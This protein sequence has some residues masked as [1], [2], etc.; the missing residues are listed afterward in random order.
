M[1][2]LRERLQAHH[3]QRRPGWQLLSLLLRLREHAHPWDRSWASVQRTRFEIRRAAKRAAAAPLVFPKVAQPRVSIVIPVFN[4]WRLTRQCLQSL[5][6]HTPLGLIEVI[7]VNDGSTD[8]TAGALTSTPGVK[9]V[10]SVR[11]VG[12]TLAANSGARAARGEFVV[13]LNNDT[14]VLPGWLEGLLGAMDDP[15]VGAAGSKLLFPKGRL[16]EAGGLVWSDATGWNIGRGDD[17]NAPQYNFLHDVD[18]CSAASLMVRAT[19]LREAGYFDERF[20]P[21]YY[22]DTDLCFTIRAL[23]YRV[24]YQPESAVV[25]LE[26]RTH[27]SDTH[28]GVA[29]AASKANQERNRPVFSAKWA[30]QLTGHAPPGRDLTRQLWGSA[31][32]PLPRVLVCDI[33]MPTPDRDSGGQRMDWLL[34]L[35]RP[36]TSLLTFVPLERAAY[37]EYASGL[38]RAGVEVFSEDYTRFADLL[39]QR[40]NVYDYVI[41]SRHQVVD[42]CLDAVRHHQP[43]ATVVFDTVD[44]HSLRFERELTVTGASS[45][46]PVK[47]LAMERRCIERTDL[48]A[49][50][51][52]LEAEILQAVVPDKRVIVVPNV[53]EVPEAPPAPFAGRRGLL[54]I[55]NFNHR[56]NVDA[57]RWFV[58]EVLP[59]IREEVDAELEVIGERP[60]AAVT[61]GAGAH[62]RFIGWVPDVRPRFDA[63][64][65]SVV[66]L[67]YGAGM[68]GKLGQALAL[69]LPSVTTSIG[70]EGMSLVDGEHV[71]VRDDPGAFADAVVQLYENAAL[72]NRLSRA[73][74]EVVRERWSPRAMR[75]RLARLSFEC[76]LTPPEAVIKAGAHLVPGTA[77]HAL[78]DL[79]KSAWVD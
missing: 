65:V 41:L 62:V 25:H 79:P 77:P 15:A 11:N 24:V 35:L 56:P 47:V 46:D 38:R 32:E 12:F 50:V 78:A 63:A 75:E 76:S 37:P 73:G 64:R 10:T 48:T 9:V 16:Q 55:A 66:P 59:R 33:L 2:G 14:Q 6:Q 18:Y 60:P 1:R 74:R 4:N 30:R 43:R 20:A 40:R 26:G 61:E 44:L 5:N 54:F 36:M 57:V 29:A 51:T 22:E 71:L 39:E 23:G 49:T 69:G 3:E 52:R 21:A 28:R 68:K 67:R 70:A 27:G 72:W 31:R 7:V 13:F 53:H 58:R 19:A 42:L 45:V 17:P 34:R 8:E